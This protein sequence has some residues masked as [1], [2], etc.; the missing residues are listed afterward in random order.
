MNRRLKEESTLVR[1]SCALL[2]WTL[3]VL[4]TAG[5]A[6]QGERRASSCCARAFSLAAI[7]AE[8]E[9]EREKKVKE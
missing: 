8:R 9:K 6:S 2:F 1:C 5:T 4:S 3:Q 7:G